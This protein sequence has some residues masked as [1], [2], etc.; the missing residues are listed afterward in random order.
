MTTLYKLTDPEQFV[1]NGVTD[2]K[3]RGEDDATI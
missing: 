1:L 3:Y 2:E